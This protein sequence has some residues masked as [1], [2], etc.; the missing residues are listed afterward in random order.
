MPR[1]MAMAMAWV[2][3]LAPNFSMMCLMWTLTVSSVMKS[4]SP[5]S[6]VTIPFGDL[7]ENFDFA[8]S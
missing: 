7:A 6:R 4:F 3:S 1:R 2:R 5:M 8:R